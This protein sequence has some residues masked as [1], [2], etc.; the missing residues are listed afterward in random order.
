MTT[1]CAWN[2]LDLPPGQS[3]PISVAY[4]DLEYPGEVVV[5][6]LWDRALGE[7]LQEER[8]F[9]VVFLKTFDSI[10]PEELRDARIAVCVP[11][12]SSLR[13]ER[14]L[15]RERRVLREVGIRYGVPETGRALQETERHLY[16]TGTVVAR[17]GP[18]ISTQAIFQEHSS[19]EWV[20]AVAWALLTWSYPRLPLDSS[21]FPRPLNAEDMGL[22]FRGLINGDN[23]PEAASAVEAFGAGLDLTPKEGRESNQSQ[24]CPVFQLLAR[25]MTRRGG[26]YPCAALYQ[27]MGHV[28]GLP[29]PLLSLYILA[30]LHMWQ[31]SA[32][33]HLRSGHRLLVS[34]G[35]PYM[36]RVVVAETVAS[37]EFVPRLEAESHLL[38]YAIPV[39]W[40]TFALYFSSLEP[41][42]SPREEEAEAPTSQ[43]IEMLKSL[44]VDERRVARALERLAG[45]VGEEVPEEAARL[46]DG[47]RVLSRAPAPE[48]ALQT[49]RHLFGSPDGLAQ[50][51]GHY[52]AL[53]QVADL[54]VL[55]IR[56]DRYLRD[57]YVPEEL[58]PLALQWQTIRAMLRLS[59]LTSVSFSAQ[60]LR[61]R[62]AGFQEEYRRVYIGHHD[63]YHPQ[64]VSL[65]GQLRDAQL[66]AQALERL[67]GIDELGEPVGAESLEVFYR[68][69][70]GLFVC[71]VPSKRLSLTRTPRCRRCSIR[72][73]QWPPSEEVGSTIQHVERSLNEQNRRLSLR[74]VHR[75]ID[76][77]KDQ[78]IDRF[79][80]VVQASDVSGLVNVLDDSLLAFLREV[81][82]ES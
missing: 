76:G 26:S 43:I 34:G 30:F 37:L 15:A 47:F 41:S 65:L 77:P 1:P 38:R 7:P 49:A 82:R 80:Q 33:L 69:L 9:R 2:L 39:S 50:A 61:E 29:Y 16:L 31:P 48:S 46:L 27:Q 12:R 22:V 17:S 3:T 23:A 68:L 78:R 64:V 44:R 71:P 81:L 42:L 58:G 14:T 28:H 63:A 53:R 60:A 11:P 67:N 54:A 8:F 6:P 56:A 55:V 57:A 36:G 5:A 51:I 59:E 79:I 25:E 10:E 35:T 62:I 18:D 70:P 45:A 72:L 19:N 21:A 52:K 13:R 66:E 32:E 75:I 20:S 4:Q 74:V 40:N 73:G 24:E